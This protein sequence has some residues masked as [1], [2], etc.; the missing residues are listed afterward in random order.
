VFRFGSL[1]LQDPSLV[2]LALRTLGTFDFSH[3]DLL[4]F[5]RECVL[6]YL[7]DNHAA[8]RKEAALTC[9]QLLLQPGACCLLSPAACL[10]SA[11]LLSTV[12]L[13]AVCLSA[14]CYL[15]STVYCLLSAV[16]CL[17][18]AACN[19]NSGYFAFFFFHLLFCA[20]LYSP[21]QSRS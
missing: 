5:V 15:L 17:F 13:S 19:L 21:L 12:C 8:I 20:I 11:C 14:V 7:D 1:L 3:R 18:P 9:A 16:C 4:P 10:L 2:S 6:M